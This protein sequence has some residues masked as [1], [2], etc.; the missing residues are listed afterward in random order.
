[1]PVR[2]FAALAFTTNRGLL[3]STCISGRTSRLQATFISA[4]KLIAL[5]GQSEKVIPSKDT[6]MVPI[7]EFRTNSVVAYQL[8]IFNQHQP[9]SCLQN[10]LIWSMP[11]YL[12]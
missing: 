3:G 12:C 8:Y 7:G 6:R 1:M 2:S 9:V 5:T 10:G 4:P 11:L